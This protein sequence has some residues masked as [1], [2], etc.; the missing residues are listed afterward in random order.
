MSTSCSLA[1]LHS[2]YLRHAGSIVA[3]VEAGAEDAV[4]VAPGDL[5]V[6][7]E[8]AEAHY[9]HQEEGQEEVN[10]TSP[11]EVVEVVVVVEESKI[12]PAA[13]E[14]CHTLEG[15]AAP[16]QAVVAAAGATAVWDIRQT[17]VVGG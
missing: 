14:D 1:S 10:R 16:I 11:Q 4:A 13:A 5:A 3:G 8:A 12:P 15:T 9:I 17:D 6:V 2:N 7:G